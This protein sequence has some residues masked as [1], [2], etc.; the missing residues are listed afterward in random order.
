MSEA[1]SRFVS[2]MVD[3]L[4]R[5]LPVKG[6]AKDPWVQGWSTIAIERSGFAVA[7]VAA[8]AAHWFEYKEKGSMNWGGV[9]S[10]SAGR[11]VD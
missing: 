1:S 7:A 8:V 6:G 9:T 3:A 10:Q 2:G 4:P 5:R 11:R